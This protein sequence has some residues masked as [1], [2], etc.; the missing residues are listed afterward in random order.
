MIVECF[1]WISHFSY[2]LCLQKRYTA[3]ARGPVF[4]CFTWCLLFVFQL[5]LM[6]YVWDVA[7][8]YNFKLLLSILVGYSIHIV[9]LVLLAIYGLTL[10]PGKNVD[11]TH[12]RVSTLAL[13]KFKFLTIFR[14]CKQ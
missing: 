2:V 14:F 10:L 1:A 3:N 6:K 9:R 12:Y 5:L 13:L 7:V 8:I 11:P 4:M